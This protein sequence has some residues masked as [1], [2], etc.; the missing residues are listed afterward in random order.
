MQAQGR[1]AHGGAAKESGGAGCPQIIP[2]GAPVPLASVTTHNSAKATV[3]YATE[4]QHDGDVRQSDKKEVIPHGS[5]PFVLVVLTK[6]VF[7]VRCL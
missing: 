3:C 6:A 7:L 2:T 1:R 4:K 5:A